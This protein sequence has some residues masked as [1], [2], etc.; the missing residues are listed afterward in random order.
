MAIATGTDNVDLAILLALI[1]ASDIYVP[2]YKATTVV[3]F[4]LCSSRDSRSQRSVIN[5]SCS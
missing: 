1:D 4:G 3:S 2:T 5:L